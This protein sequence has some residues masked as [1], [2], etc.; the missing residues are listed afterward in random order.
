MALH[1]RAS[2]LLLLLLT[3][4]ASAPTDGNTKSTTTKS[5]LDPYER[6]VLT[7]S[8]PTIPD[9]TDPTLLVPTCKKLPALKYQELNHGF[10]PPLL[11]LT[12][13]PSHLRQL[14]TQRVGSRVLMELLMYHTTRVADSDGEAATQICEAVVT[15]MDSEEGES[16]WE[17]PVAHVLVKNWLKTESEHGE[18][19][20]ATALCQASE[21]GESLW[22]HPV[23]HVLVKN[24]LKTES[25]H[26][27]SPMATALCQ[28]YKGKL[29][30][31]MAQT[32]R[33][34]FC[35]LALASTTDANL[36]KSIAAEL[37]KGRKELSKKCDGTH[38]KGYEAL[39]EAIPK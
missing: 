27:E 36:K 12:Q 32:N 24:W 28:A 30:S 20:M 25:E 3:N 21:E 23:A 4:G 34:A 22:E 11:E 8:P 37:K 33:G 9:P 6:S 5:F 7:P 16:L 17:H 19:P 15:A 2:K 35:L 26:G 39:L 18:S 13:R 31:Q 29:V 38:T 1:E 14:L 10:L